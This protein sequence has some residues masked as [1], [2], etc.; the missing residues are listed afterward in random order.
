MRVVIAGA[1]DVGKRDI[2]NK[3]DLPIF[4]EST[5]YLPRSLDLSV[6][7]LTDYR[8]EIALASQRAIAMMTQ[9]DCI[10]IG[11]P[12]DNLL[13]EVIRFEIG[14]NAELFEE[15]EEVRHYL[16]SAILFGIFIDS[17]IADV[18]FF[19]PQEAETMDFAGRINDFYPQLF[20]MYSLPYTTL[21]GTLEEKIDK[22]RATIAEWERSRSQSGTIE[23]GAEESE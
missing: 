3:L 7:Q 9:D 21:T 8:V 15:E 10:W 5:D 17:F 6:G 4:G 2:G 22:A 1:P 13:H 12:L 18:I 20:E 14:H 19:V 16:T 23:S 11:T